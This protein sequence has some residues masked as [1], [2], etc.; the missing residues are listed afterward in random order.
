MASLKENSLERYLSEADQYYT[1]VP[2]TTNQMTSTKYTNQGYHGL[3]VYGVKYQFWD[4]IRVR[5][6]VD[7]EPCIISWNEKID[8][9]WIQYTVDKH[10][11]WYWDFYFG[12]HA[13]LYEFFSV[14]MYDDSIEIWPESADESCIYTTD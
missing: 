10:Y 14:S 5:K 4:A 8:N 6:I 1:G 3:F 12:E 9:G 7:P 13:G 2:Q 11:P